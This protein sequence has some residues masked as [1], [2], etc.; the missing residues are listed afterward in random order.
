MGWRFPSPPSPS[1][2]VTLRSALHAIDP[3]STT[4]RF[5]FQWA[6]SQNLDRICSSFCFFPRS[7]GSF[8]RTKQTREHRMTRFSLRQGSGIK[9]MDR[10]YGRPVYPSSP[11]INS[12]A[13][14]PENFLVSDTAQPVSRRDFMSVLANM[15]RLMVRASYSTEPSAVYRYRNT[16]SQRIPHDLKWQLCFGFSTFRLA[17]N[18]LKR[19]TVSKVLT[20]L[21]VSLDCTY[22]PC[23]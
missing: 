1:A 20:C 2:V 17:C 23:K 3:F 7:F 14:L 15:T 22:S 10:R 18:E 19:T 4:A 16:L 13:L 11:S 21:C 5:T 8:E 6:C 12:I 9:I